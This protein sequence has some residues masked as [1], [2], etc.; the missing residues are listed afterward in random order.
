MTRVG[1]Q[2]SREMAQPR[3]VI[4]PYYRDQYGEWYKDYG[5]G[6][7]PITLSPAQKD[8]IE[9]QVIRRDTR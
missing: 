5:P 4:G 1:P 6:V 7:R 3:H 2:R 9:R 8:E